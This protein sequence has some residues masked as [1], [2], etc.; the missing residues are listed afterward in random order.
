MGGD[1]IPALNDETNYKDWKARVK[2]WRIGTDCKKTAQAAKLISWMSGKPE[3]VALQ[4]DERKIEAEDGL[5]YLIAELDK[6]F[7]EDKTQSVFCAIDHFNSYKRP[8]STTMD[9]YVREFQQR[10][11]ALVQIRAK[12]DLYEDGIL[13]YQ[14]LSQANLD[15]DQERLIRATVSDLS[16]DN[17]E[18]ALKRTFGEGVQAQTVG[19][20]ST[21]SSSSHMNY[22][23][24]SYKIGTG[25]IK[26]E[27]TYFTGNVQD[28]K[29][30][31][32][33]GNKNS[34]F[35]ES[36]SR[37]DPRDCS[38]C[39][40]DVNHR[41]DTESEHISDDEE[42]FFI[43]GNK[44]RKVNENS[45][46]RANSGRNNTYSGRNNNYSRGKSYQQSSRS[47]NNDHQMKKKG[48]CFI[49]GDP[50]HHVAECPHNT[51]S[52]KEKESTKPD[53]KTFFKSD[54]ELPDSNEQI[55][56]LMGETANK[57]LLD[58]GACTQFVVK[59]SSK[60]LKT[61]SLKMKKI[62]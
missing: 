33:G 45:G 48:S 53:Y 58:T 52:K 26:E 19:S 38:D 41:S 5:T 37:R 14:L 12:G 49:C 10:Y 6:L 1:R 32:S 17:I 51:F 13:A 42:V 30:Q 8:A 20:S 39:S 18:K 60:F 43:N 47:Y 61:R 46:Y 28:R 3:E 40:Y 50:T 27:P 29:R 7:E 15:K 4:L 59:N 44:Y 57:A 24:N 9:Q 36:N 2:M 31:F 56:Y 21:K 25:N 16:Y 23:S 55:S 34:S 22:G 35:G 62:I 54:F 11:K